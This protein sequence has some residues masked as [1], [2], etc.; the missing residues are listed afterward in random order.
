MKRLILYSIFCLLC[1]VSQANYKIQHKVGETVIGGGFDFL[2]EAQLN[3]WGGECFLKVR[4]PTNKHK[5]P[6]VEGNKIRWRDDDVDINMYPLS[7]EDFEY[8]V[9]LKTPSTNIVSLDIETKGLD[10]F[11]QPELTQKEKDEGY[12]RP[13]NVIGSYAVYHK[14]KANN[15]YKTGKAFHIYRP[16]IIDSDGDWIWGLLDIK[17][18]KLTISIDPDWLDIAQYPVTVDPTF[19]Y[20]S[21]GASSYPVANCLAMAGATYLY[22]ATTGDMIESFHVYGTSSAGATGFDMAAYTVSGGVPVTG[23]AAGT[24]VVLPAVAGWGSTNVS[25]A[26]SNGVTYC[27]AVG[28][29]GA[30][31]ENL[32]YDSGTG[33]NRS[34]DVLTS[35]LPATWTHDNWSASR[36]SI[37]AT[38][39]AAAP[40]AGGGAQVIIIEME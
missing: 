18:K 2:P 1:S 31:T 40:P 10:F 29:D 9:V 17:G 27:V 21:A 5:E 22:T 33:N 14:S 6:M 3:R 13:E 35:A 25:Q 23:L 15:K 12:F 39:S 34:V 16:K 8:E 30:A 20:T 38:Y 7:D 37:Y 4:Y 19:G 26:M 32:Y 28:N 24:T 36:W 11:Y